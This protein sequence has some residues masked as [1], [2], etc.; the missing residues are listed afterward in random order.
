MVRV[1]GYNALFTTLDPKLQD[2][3]IERTDK[4]AV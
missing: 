3:T 2:D 1:A 4:M